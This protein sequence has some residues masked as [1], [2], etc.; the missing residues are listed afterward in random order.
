MHSV[1]WGSSPRV[2][3]RPIQLICISDIYLY[4]PTDKYKRHSRVICYTERGQCDGRRSSCK[5]CSV[6]PTR[7][8]LRGRHGSR[9]DYNGCRRTRRHNNQQLTIKHKDL[10]LALG[11]WGAIV[12]TRRRA[13]PDVSLSQSSPDHAPPEQVIRALQKHQRLKCGSLWHVRSTSDPIIDIF[14]K[15][16]SVQDITKVTRWAAQE[17]K[18]V[19]NTKF[20]SPVWVIQWVQCFAVSE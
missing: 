14:A 12:R 8:G 16:F 17:S 1:W 7:W 18:W 13:S 11:I 9:H 4:M 5:T 6:R 10:W 19:K 15:K 2:V 20:W 3:D